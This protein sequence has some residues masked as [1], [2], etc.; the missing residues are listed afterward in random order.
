ME[1]AIDMRGVSKKYQGFSL[2]H[3]DFKLPK[4]RVIGLIGENGAGKTTLI[5]A[6]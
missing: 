1:Y 2:D 5:K 4:G 3:V 6:A